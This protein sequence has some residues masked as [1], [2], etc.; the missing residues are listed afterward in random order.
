MAQKSLG[1]SKEARRDMTHLAS[2]A[3]GR[4]RISTQ[5]GGAVGVPGMSRILAVPIHGAEDEVLELPKDDLPDDPNEIMQIL[6]NELAPL[7]LWLELA[8]SYYQQSRIEQFSIV[9]ETSTGDEGTPTS[10]AF[11]RGPRPSVRAPAS[12]RMLTGSRPPPCARARQVHST[13]TS[14][15]TTRRGASRCS[16]AWPPTTRP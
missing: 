8:V 10:P 16:P 13:R 14:T 2:L 9:M 12:S 15:R 4:T 3:A 11:M 6:A 1:R 7:K 5:G